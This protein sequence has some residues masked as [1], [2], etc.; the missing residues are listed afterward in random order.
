MTGTRQLDVQETQLQQQQLLLLL[1][2]LL[3]VQVYTK[4]HIEV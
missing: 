2:L 4:H 3:S 1:L